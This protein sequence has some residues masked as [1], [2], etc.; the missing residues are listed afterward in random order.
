MKIAADWR[1]VNCV[2]GVQTPAFVER[3]NLY[4]FRMSGDGVSPEFRLRPSLSGPSRRRH[5]FTTADRPCV[6]GVQTP[7]FVER[8][9]ADGA[10]GLT[11][12]SV[13]S[14][15]FR[16]RPSLSAGSAMPLG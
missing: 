16:L 15:E 4:A 5:P 2:A 12:D 8:W 1:L 9:Q 13:V 7:A 6:A 11:A 14:P 10:P 3:S